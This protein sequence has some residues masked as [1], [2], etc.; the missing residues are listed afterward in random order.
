MPKLTDTIAV[1]TGAARG[2]GQCIA[3]ELAA[4]GADLV[5]CDL[6]EDW[7][8]ESKAK[9][10]ALGRR[11]VT[12]GMDVSDADSVEAGMKRAIEECGRID[13]LVNNAGITKDMLLLR[14]SEEDWRAVLDINLTGAFLCTKA[15]MRGMM[16]QRRGAIV[17]LASVIGLMGNAGQANYA[18]SKGG[19]IAFTK[20]VAKEMAS[21]GVRANAVAPG[22]INT[23]MT[24]KLPD[25]VKEQMT[26][27]IPLGRMGEPEEVAKV[28]AF[29]ASDEAGYMTGQVISICGGMVMA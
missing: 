21:R 10:A 19:L 2:I 12:I 18:A 28:V 23:A 24:D 8:G 29:L 4:E 11:A 27:L 25:Q 26:G 15:V 14:M 7:L 3:V 17:N 16:K 1:V 9:I 22:Y 13:V 20:S 6:E 5:L